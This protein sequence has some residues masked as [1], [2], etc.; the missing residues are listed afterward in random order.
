MADNRRRNGLTRRKFFKSAA[1]TPVLGAFAYSVIK[2]A[3][4]DDK[5]RREI[6]SLAET[7]AQNHPIIQRKKRKLKLSPSANDTINI[8]YI[9]LGSRGKSHMRTAGFI[10]EAERSS[11]GLIAQCRM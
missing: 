11:A 6:L 9:G 3:E 1:T 10:P 4:L 7:S 2:K 5:G 8:G